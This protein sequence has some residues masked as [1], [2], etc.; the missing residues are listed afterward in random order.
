MNTKEIVEKL[1]AAKEKYYAGKSVMTDFE[2]DAMEDM[3]R[4]Q[5]SS[6]DYFTIVG[7][8]VKGNIKQKV[9]HEVPM[10]SCDKAQNIGEALAWVKKIGVENEI[11]IGEPKIDGMSA[12]IV[13]DN[14]KF[15][16]VASRGDGITGQII[17]HIV[18]QIA[19]V[20][21]K[22]INLK[23]RV[24]IRG[25]LYLPKNSKI[26]NPEN[27]PLRNM[28]TG[29]V[30]RKGENH[31]LDDLKFVHFVAYQIVGSD[32]DSESMKMKWLGKYFETVE[33]KLLKVAEIENYYNEY[34][35]TLRSEWNY[36]TDG[37]VLV[38][39]DNT[40]WE[41]IN[42]KYEISHHAYH[43]LAFKGPSE[44]KETILT[45]IE[46]NVS[47]QGKLIPVA[48]FESVNLGGANTSRCTLNNYENV[49]RLKLHKGDKIIISR[50]NDVIP[51]L[52]S[53]LT[54]HA[55]HSEYLIP[56]HCP[57]CDSKLK[58]DG[59]QLICNN[60]DCKEQKILIVSHWVTNIGVENFSESSVRILFESK[61]IKSISD[62]YKLT[63]K[64]LSDVPGFG[65]SK[66]KNL[67]EQ[68]GKTKEMT[69]AK[70]IDL[71]SIDLV[72]EKAVKK[73]GI[74]TIEDFLN[75]SD[76][77]YVIGKNIMEYVKENN[78]YIKELLS[79]VKI[80]Q[81]KEVDKNAR[82]VCFTG[83]GPKSR[84]DLVKDIQ[85]KG[86]VYSDSVSKDLNILVCD[87]VN[88]SSSK[89][90]KAKKLGVKIMTYPE[91]FN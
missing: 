91:Y 61:K 78:A 80:K 8:E 86:D 44:A 33:C 60:K 12:G 63:A 87:D 32:M 10:L 45:G 57:S 58:V 84:N 51:M 38:V 52:R 5:D 17:T 24:E 9:K 1:M 74:N 66:T 22:T 55:K 40:K 14:G 41:S 70:Y 48:L 89:I 39:D 90:Q 42:S 56:T 2:F 49:L 73:L 31:S 23:G 28:C 3:L 76:D 6:N 50:Q 88:G 26:P 64:D 13:Y 15:K 85:A 7:S 83:A 37:L 75:F 19:T 21:A 71:L 82:K 35:D 69:L 36:E 29:L 54:I 4:K 20:I 11:I 34:L 27:K 30:G 77:T 53:V 68:L 16:H 47:R 62:L 81:E 65:D 43:N 79:V 59:I 46:W 72:G 25:E 18:G 67:F